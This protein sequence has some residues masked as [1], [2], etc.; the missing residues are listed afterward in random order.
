MVGALGR[1]V[2]YAWRRLQMSGARVKG[3]AQLA[4]QAGA[5]LPSSRFERQPNACRVSHA[6]ACAVGPIH[7]LKASSFLDGRSRPDAHTNA[8][9]RHTCVISPLLKSPITRWRTTMVT[10]LAIRICGSASAARD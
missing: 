10:P 1:P 2:S 5:A 6:V 3:L 4:A 8:P 7:M 9:A